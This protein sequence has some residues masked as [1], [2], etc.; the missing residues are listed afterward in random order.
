MQAQETSFND[1]KLKLPEFH[2]MVPGDR[3]LVLLAGS[4]NYY[5]FQRIRESKETL[6]GGT[7]AG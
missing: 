7:P 6:T 4:A 5:S 3:G 1:M 2:E